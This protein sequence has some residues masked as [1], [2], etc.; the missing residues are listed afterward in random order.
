MSVN[1]ADPIAA[2]HAAARARWPDIALPL[3]AFAEHL[4]ARPEAECSEDVFLA[5][6]CLAR[7]PAALAVL[8]REL[9]DVVSGAV[10]SLERADDVAAEAAQ[11]TRVALLV[12]GRS[13]GG[14]ALASYAGRGALRR[15]IRVVAVREAMRLRDQRRRMVAVDDQSMLDALIPPGDPALSQIKNEAAAHV[16]AAFLEALGELE[17]RERTALRMHLLDGLTV[18]EVAPVFQIH[19]ATAARWIAAA[20]DRLLSIARRKL[21]ARLALDRGEVDSLIRL[22]RSRLDFGNALK[23]S[24]S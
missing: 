3:E 13:G 11:A 22:A 6:A 20:R 14:P 4:R 5:C 23:S 15:F 2:A 9:V 1:E 17:R 8:E 7:D 10:G 12:E 18:D 16:R 19:R 21:E 24:D